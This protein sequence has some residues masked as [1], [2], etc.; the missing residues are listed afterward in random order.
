MQSLDMIL[1]I[2]LLW[3]FDRLATI[4]NCTGADII[5]SVTLLAFL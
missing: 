3:G 2:D 1:Q 5:L 4:F